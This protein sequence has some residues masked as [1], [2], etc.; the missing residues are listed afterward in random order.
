MM[1]I[2]PYLDTGEGR[3]ELLKI[4]AKKRKAIALT[5]EKLGHTDLIEMCIRLTENSKP[6]ALRPYK[7]AHSK[8]KYLDKEIDRLLSEGIITPTISPWR[9]PCLLVPK[10]MIF[11]VYA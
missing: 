3:F 9:C 8:E 2:T 11:T 1:V 6:V 7:L 5:G 10:K 4:L